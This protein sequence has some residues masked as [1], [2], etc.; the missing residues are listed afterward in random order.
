MSLL[1]VSSLEYREIFFLKHEFSYSEVCNFLERFLDELSVFLL[2]RCLAFLFI[3][4]FNK[5]INEHTDCYLKVDD[6]L[7]KIT[8]RGLL[9]ETFEMLSVLFPSSVSSS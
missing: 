1:I 2:P 4:I 5:A 8:I 3:R 7:L 6:T 9:I